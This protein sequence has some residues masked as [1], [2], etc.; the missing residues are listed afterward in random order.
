MRDFTV[1]TEILSLDERYKISSM[2][3]SRGEYEMTSLSFLEDG[4]EIDFW[5]NDH[6]LYYH[7]YPYLKGEMFR[8]DPSYQKIHPFFKGGVHT[9]KEMFDKAFQLGFF[10]NTI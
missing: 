6:F 3:N 7:V 9:V 8:T 1:Y 5:D 2:M 4:K 10:K